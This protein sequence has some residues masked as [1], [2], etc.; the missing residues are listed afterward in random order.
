[1]SEPLRDPPAAVRVTVRC[2]AAVREA[3]GVEVLVV[4]LPAGSTVAALREELGRRAPLL[5]RL[6]LAYARNRAY[7]TAATVLHDGDEVALIPPI[8]GGGEPPF[9]FTLQHDP[10]EARELERQCRTD[11][12][13]AV[14]TFAGVTRD[15]NDGA[16]VVSLAYEAYAEMA[17][18]LAT[19]IFTE[20]QQR[21]AITRARITHRLGTVPVGEAAVVVVVSAA[22]RG[23]AFD[24]CRYLMDR[25]KH[26]VPIWKREQLQHD[27]GTRWVGELPRPEGGPATGSA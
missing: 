14:V 17:T 1:M 13:G 18:A 9:R 16:R 27:G 25:L 12:D 21:F 19:A 5:A 8:S 2:F 15:H 10:L 23:P 22:H 7:A 11:H 26:E 4:A 20:A 6:A 24:A 3:L